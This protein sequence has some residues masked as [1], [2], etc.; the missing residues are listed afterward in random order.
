MSGGKASVVASVHG[1]QHI[2]C[3]RA[4]YLANDD[5]VW[6]HTQAGADQTLDVNFFT[7]ARRRRCIA[8][9]QPHDVR[10]LSDLQL[11]RILD[12]DDTLIMRDIIGKCI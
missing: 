5:A 10:N 6:T 4:A 12:G 3:F 9:L 7:L 8:G 11:S 2:Q 1:L